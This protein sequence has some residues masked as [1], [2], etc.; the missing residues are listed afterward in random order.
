MLPS[1]RVSK[2]Q[3]AAMEPGW[4]RDALEAHVLLRN[5]K[6]Y[7]NSKKR[8]D[9]AHA[10]FQKAYHEASKPGSGAQR[11][12]LA[13]ISLWDGISLQENLDLP[14]NVQRNDLAIERYR[15][16]L[17]HA[18]YSRVAEILPVRMS[19]HN[20]MGVAFHH[21]NGNY[22]PHDA[23]ASYR[24]AKDI[25]DAHPEERER[26]QHIMK[27]VIQNSG[28]FGEAHGGGGCI[29]GNGSFEG[30]NCAV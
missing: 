12:D 23:M 5:G 17:H 21:R 25:Y 7:V 6:D 10:L 4:V 24:R 27:K 15:D 2:K 13:R 14:D 20:S 19:I 29:G 18:Q 3:L 28:N 16:G 9:K 26:L 30:G 22:V 8:Y 1:G 11:I